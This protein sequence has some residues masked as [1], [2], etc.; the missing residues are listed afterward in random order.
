MTEPMLIDRL[1]EARAAL[2][3][4]APLVHAERPDYLDCGAWGKCE[5]YHDAMRSI[6]RAAEAIGVP[7]AEF[8]SLGVN[9]V[10]SRIEDRAGLWA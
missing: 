3:E 9:R 7:V 4:L 5:A 8:A 1:V 2:L 10:A 6:T